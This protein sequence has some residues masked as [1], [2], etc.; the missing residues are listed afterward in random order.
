MLEPERSRL[1]R[2]VERKKMLDQAVLRD[3]TASVPTYRLED[4]AGFILRQASQRHAAIFN[5]GAGSDIT[6]TQWAALAKLNEVGPLSQNLLGRLTVMDAATIKGVVDRLT[7]RG[8]IKTCPDFADRR[9]RVVSL[10]EDGSDLVRQMIP[11]ATKITE[12]TL[13]PLRHEERTLLIDLLS[14]LR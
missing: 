12:D 6:M 1:D 9:R 2:N 7:Q 14:K 11:K 13:A 10:T 4:Q 8:L 5:A 3:Q